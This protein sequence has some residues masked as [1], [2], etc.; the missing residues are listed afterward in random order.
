MAGATGSGEVRRF[1]IFIATITRNR[2]QNIERGSDALDLRLSEFK[3]KERNCISDM[4]VLAQSGADNN[5]TDCLTSEQIV[6]D[7]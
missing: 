7:R 3:I 6:A 5:G 4:C 2:I 1:A